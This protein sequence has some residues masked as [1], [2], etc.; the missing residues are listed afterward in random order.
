MKVTI[1]SYS[2]DQLYLNVD[3]HAD[4]LVAP[5]GTEAISGTYYEGDHP[6][7]TLKFRSKQGQVTVYLEDEQVKEV[8]KALRSAKDV[9]FD[10]DVSDIKKIAVSLTRS[11]KERP[12]A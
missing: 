3:I 9:V 7:Y 5:P 4:S 12:N 11:L 6:F 2:G 1:D 8:F 10:E